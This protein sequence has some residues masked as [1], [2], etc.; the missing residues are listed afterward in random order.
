MTTLT[1]LFTTIAV[2]FSAFAVTGVAAFSPLY[3]ETQFN[4]TVVTA[5]IAAGSV[6]ESDS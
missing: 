3:Y 6:C 2:S 5:S 1:W 4:L